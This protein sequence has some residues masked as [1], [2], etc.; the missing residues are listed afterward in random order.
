MIDSL[1]FFNKKFAKENI[2]SL[3][4]EEHK[5]R[6]SITK[7]LANLSKNDSI[8]N[9]REIEQIKKNHHNY[10]EQHMAFMRSIVRVRRSIHH[11]Q[12]HKYCFTKFQN[13]G[14]R[15]IQSIICPL[16]GNT[17]TDKYDI[18]EAFAKYHES[19]VAAADTQN[20]ELK[21]GIDDDPDK[22]LMQRILDKHSLNLN[23]FFP[24][25]HQE[26]GPVMFSYAEIARSI[27]SFKND[28][29][30][31]P[32]GQGKQF[33]TFLFRFNKPFFTIAIN[34]LLNLPEIDSTSFAW[35][36]RRKIVFIKKKKTQ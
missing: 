12:S 25:L 3:K 34:Q 17:L 35:V 7:A 36:K 33:F 11:A 13:R 31:G 32:S 27:A 4:R 20:D 10:I 29:A 28:S 22:S 15:T 30:P 24:Q 5:Y 14:H 21:A 23:D 8:E 6:I 18:A 1:S 19:K 2:S 26:V 16:T 9:R